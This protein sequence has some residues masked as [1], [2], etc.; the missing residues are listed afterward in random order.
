M[1]EWCY[2]CKS[3]VETTNHLLIHCEV[4]RELW[5]LVFSI[6][7]IQWAMPES[8]RDLLACW[9]WKSERGDRGLA[10]RVVPLCLFWC[11]WRE[12][13]FRAFEDIEDSLIF[14]KAS[15]LSSFFLWMRRDFPSN[16]FSLVGFLGG[17][18][19]TPTPRV[20]MVAE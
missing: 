13:N 16:P 8:V 18:S 9:S 6:F 17:F 19:P 20:S 10:W 5:N 12:R 15:F 11:L 3:N 7:G 2:M 14:L 1:T 4:A